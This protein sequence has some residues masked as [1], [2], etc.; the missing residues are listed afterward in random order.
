MVKIYFVYFKYPLRAKIKPPFPVVGIKSEHSNLCTQ[1]I[2]GVRRLG[3][4]HHTII[5]IFRSEYYK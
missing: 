4:L 3:S 5:K 2:S 1:N